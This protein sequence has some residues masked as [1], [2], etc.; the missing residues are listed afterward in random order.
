MEKETVN[1]K[2][3]SNIVVNKKVKKVISVL[4]ILFVILIV[5]V[6]FV[7]YF[8]IDLNVFVSIKEIENPVL[9]FFADI[10]ATIF[11]TIN[12]LSNFLVKYVSPLE[13]LDN[14]SSFFLN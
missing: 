5:V 9:R 14:C 11:C 8:F 10:F 6:P 2:L 7:N 13:N 12:F 3:K 4:F 1:K